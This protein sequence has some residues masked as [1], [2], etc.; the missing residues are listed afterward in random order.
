MKQMKLFNSLK[1]RYQN[2]LESIKSS[3]SIF[4]Y[5]DLMHNKCHKINPTRGRS[6]IDCPNWIKKQ[7]TVSP[8]NKKD[9][10]SFQYA[11]TGFLNYKKYENM[12]KD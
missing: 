12:L 8:I 7:A 2:Y 9:N 5:F 6:Y 3:E 10:E 11:I 4:D 1:N